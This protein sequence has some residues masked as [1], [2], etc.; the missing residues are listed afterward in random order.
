ME[1]G[2]SDHG[3]EMTQC[4]CTAG[5]LADLHWGQG[6]GT[7]RQTD[8]NLF[9]TIKS[10]RHAPARCAPH[11]WLVISHLCTCTYL[12]WG[13]IWR[14]WWPSSFLMLQH[15]LLVSGI[16]NMAV[17]WNPHGKFTVGLSWQYLALKGDDK[18]Q[19][20]LTPLPKV[21]CLCKYCCICNRGN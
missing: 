6:Y 7:Y 9:V 3:I 20:N 10:V 21:H 11:A 1:C 4:S 2:Y 14:N 19:H 12:L 15:N 18:N 16:M 8:T 13:V 17:F 5:G